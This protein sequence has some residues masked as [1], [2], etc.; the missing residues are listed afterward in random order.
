MKEILKALW[1]SWLRKLY[2]D[3][4]EE[5]KQARIHLI[6]QANEHHK[7]LNDKEQYLINKLAELA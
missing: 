7:A 2:Q 6:D 1:R 5:L 3:K 4:L